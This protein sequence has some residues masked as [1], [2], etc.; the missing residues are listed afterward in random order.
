MARLILD[1]AKLEA[2]YVTYSTI[3][4]MALQNTP[5]IYPDIAMVMNGV[6]PVTQI[7]WLDDMPVMQEWLGNRVI[8]R[9]RAEGL[10][11][12]TRW[13][14]N[15][16][17]AD[18]DDISEDRTG[19][20]A[21]RLRNLAMMGPRKIDAVVI[22][23]LNRGF[24]GTLGLTYDGQ[25]LFDTDHTAE[26]NGG[27]AQSNVVT[28]VLSSATLNAGLAAMMQFKGS[29]GE[30]LS[31]QPDTILVGPA[32]Q[33]VVRQLLIAAYGPG[34][35]SN[36]DSGIVKAVVNARISGAYAPQWYL[37]STAN[38]ASRPV[39]VGIE[40]PPEFAEV[41]GWDK[42]HQFMHRTI[43]FGAHMKVGFQLGLWQGAVGG[44][45]V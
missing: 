11:L 29:N 20:I 3:F 23:Y 26:G 15:G 2:A 39:V 5:V 22:D 7:N 24:G 27:T 25:Y 32:N 9:L 28:G 35:A 45:G 10:L 4:D 33:L 43:L 6:G 42:E 13:Y 36:I 30:P 18:V 8:Q 38:E 16:L 12:R 19:M 34:G 17:E 40:N 44:T 14:A 31:I 37:L 21:P 41:S 1:R